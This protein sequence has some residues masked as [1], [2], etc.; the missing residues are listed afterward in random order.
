MLFMHMCMVYVYI[1]I[2]VCTCVC[3]CV[4]CVYSVNWK[5]YASSRNPNCRSLRVIQTSQTVKNLLRVI[6][7]SQTVKNLPA[8]WVTWVQSLCGKIPRRRK[9]QPTPVFLPGKVHGQRSLIG[10]RPWGHKESDM[11]EQL[12]LS[13]TLRVIHFFQL[14]DCIYVCTWLFQCIHVFE[15]TCNNDSLLSQHE[16]TNYF[17]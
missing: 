14:H 12:M 5:D 10:Y 13:K 17:L 2:W 16:A 9:W 3:I 15:K 1:H 11:T 4:M 7:T 6:Q 8:M